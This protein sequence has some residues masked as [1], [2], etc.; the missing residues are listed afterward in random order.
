MKATAHTSSSSEGWQFEIANLIVYVLRERS[1]PAGRGYIV[2]IQEDGMGEG[3][4]VGKVARV[5]QVYPLL[6]ALQKIVE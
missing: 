6:R 5:H 1:G 2:T 4:E 3:V